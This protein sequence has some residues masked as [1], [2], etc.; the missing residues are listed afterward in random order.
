MKDLFDKI[1]NKKGPLGQV[2]FEVGFH[3]LMARQSKKFA[4]ICV[5]PFRKRRPQ[6]KH[7]LFV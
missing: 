3:D 6:T 5:Q 1:E 4:Q 2:F 7:V